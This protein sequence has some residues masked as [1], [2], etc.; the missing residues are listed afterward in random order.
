MILRKI[1]ALVSLLTTALLMKHAVFL[2][3]W[4]LSRGSMAKADNGMPFVLAALMVIHALI[5]IILGILVHKGTK[6]Q[7][8]KSY[9]KMNIPTIVQRATGIMMIVLLGL[10]ISGSANHFQPKMLHAVIHPLFFAAAL[11]H[12]SISASKAMITLGIG[13]AKTVKVVDAVMKIICIAT[14]AASVVGF[15]LCL[16]VGVVR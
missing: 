14:F 15:Y 6:K 13:N 4:M 7:A 10:H 9:P 16:F 8:C 11:A 12:T 2:S 1:N 5:S 3:I